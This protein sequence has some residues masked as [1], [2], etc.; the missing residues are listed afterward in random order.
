M[1]WDVAQQLF[2]NPKRVKVFTIDGCADS[3]LKT[4]N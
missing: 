1:D 4:L 2:V 3:G